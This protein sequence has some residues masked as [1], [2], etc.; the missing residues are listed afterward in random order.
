MIEAASKHHQ[1]ACR[2]LERSVIGR[3]GGEEFIV[4]IP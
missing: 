3:W 4:F 2:G 1:N